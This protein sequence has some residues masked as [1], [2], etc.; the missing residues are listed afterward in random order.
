M[1]G[2]TGTSF[3]GTCSINRTLPNVQVSFPSKKILANIFSI[4]EEYFS[5]ETIQEDIV[6]LDKTVLFGRQW[7]RIPWL[8]K[9]WLTKFSLS[10]R[11]CCF[12]GGYVDVRFSWI[13][14]LSTTDTLDSCNQ[15]SVCQAL[16]PKCFVWNKNG[17]MRV[18][19]LFVELRHESL[20]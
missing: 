15:Q 19:K 17:C 16:E 10:R 20:A 11:N 6:S 7:S 2:D 12:G 14:C 9:I 5:C 4:S 13:D 3:S 8:L 1:L 18:L